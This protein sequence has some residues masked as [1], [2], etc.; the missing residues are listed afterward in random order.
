MTE[1]D[2]LTVLD[3]G[4]QTQVWQV[5]ASPEGAREGCVLPSFRWPWTFLS[6]QILQS[7]ILTWPSFYK[8][9]S[10][11]GLENH[12]PPVAPHFFN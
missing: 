2:F 8:E 4:I 11:I 6:F 7:S 10:H 5:H 12:A 9:A 3:S 1:I